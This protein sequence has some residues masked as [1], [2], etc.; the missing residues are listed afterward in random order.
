MVRAVA[1]V[2]LLSASFPELFT[3]LQGF[4]DNPCANPHAILPVGEG[5]QPAPGLGKNLQ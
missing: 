3:D 2:L 4:N 1:A 5:S